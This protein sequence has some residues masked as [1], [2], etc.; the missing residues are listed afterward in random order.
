MRR[1]AS[2]RC[3]RLSHRAVPYLLAFHEAAELRVVAVAFCRLARTVVLEVDG[4]QPVDIR[5]GRGRR[6]PTPSRRSDGIAS[7]PFC[8]ISRVSDDSTLSAIIGMRCMRAK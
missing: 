5:L 6:S 4:K 1:A 8:E 2:L 3:Q 7:S